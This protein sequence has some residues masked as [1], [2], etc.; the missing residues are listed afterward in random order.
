MSDDLSNFFAKKAAKKEK[1][2]KAGIVK[3]EEVGSAL[4]R[5]SQR[6]EPIS[7][8]V[9]REDAPNNNAEAEVQQRKPDGEESE[10]LEFSENKL[11]LAEVGLKDMNLTEQVEEQR[12]VEEK[13]KAA[14]AAEVKTW[15]MD[16]KKQKEEDDEEEEAPAQA[17]VPAQPAEPV[18]RAYKP[19]GSRTTN[20]MS[21][22]N[23]MNLDLNNQDMFPTFAAA[24]EQ[25]Q[26]QK[27]VATKRDDNKGA[28]SM[29]TT[30]SQTQR[31][32]TQAAPM[33][34]RNTFRALDDQRDVP[35][36]S[37]SQAPKKGSYVPPHLRRMQQQS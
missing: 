15:N 31:T 7:T 36:P 24:E 21:N 2:K 33:I 6:R 3:V 32:T 12:K 18:K 22:S 5:R 28:W 20:S 14:A 23:R 29:S 25:M 19:P 13:E 1:K 11:R 9:T 34:T 16:K 17:P 35:A 8:T 30:R 27:D 37:A 10:W 4:E 26:K